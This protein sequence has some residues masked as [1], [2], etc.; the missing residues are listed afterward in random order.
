LISICGGG[1]VGACVGVATGVG[2]FG[3]GVP[4]EGVGDA[5]GDVKGGVGGTE[6]GCASAESLRLNFN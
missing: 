3:T 2:V 6:V 1:G 5:N 4:S